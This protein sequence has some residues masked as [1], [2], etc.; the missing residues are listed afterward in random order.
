MACFKVL[1][2]YSPGSA[3]KKQEISDTPLKIGENVLVDFLY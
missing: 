2:R 3:E 1:A